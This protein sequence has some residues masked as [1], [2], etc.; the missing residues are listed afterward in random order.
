M[1]DAAGLFRR[2]VGIGAQ[3]DLDTALRYMPAVHFLRDHPEVHSILEVGSGS[4]GIGPYVDRQFVATDVRFPESTN[5]NL[6]PV[7][8]QNPLPFRDRTF[9]VVLS[10]DTLEHV[11]RESRQ[12]FVTEMLRLSRGYLLVGFPQ[13]ERSV[14]HD[15][16]M[17][18]YYTRTM[19]DPH[20]YF[21]DHRTYGIPREGE[22]AMYLEHATRQ[23]G[24]HVSWRAE[25]N[26]CDACTSACSGILPEASSASIPPSLRWLAGIGCFAWASA[27]GTSTLSQSRRSLGRDAERQGGLSSLPLTLLGISLPWL[28]KRT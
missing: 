27:T 8:A 16:E 25:R 19:G 17:E 11:P 1:S 23:I 13:G 4:Q 7:I 12:N 14:H 28:R 9:D 22:F 6:I 10:L 20:E 15:T 5:P 2:M 3:W 21:V 24:R 18:A 26:A